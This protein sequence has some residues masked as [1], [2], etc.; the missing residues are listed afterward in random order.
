MTIQLEKAEKNMKRTTKVASTYRDELSRLNSKSLLAEQVIATITTEK[1][2]KIQTLEEELK[3]MKEEIEREKE[4]KR[5][6]EEKKNKS[7]ICVIS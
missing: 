2:K 1:E 6:E 4:L 7:K 5:I 3:K